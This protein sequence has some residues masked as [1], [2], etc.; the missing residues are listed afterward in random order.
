MALG[1]Y[2]RRPGA[3]SAA[4][5]G[6]FAGLAYATKETFVIVAGGALLALAI[7][8][9]W[10]AKT[11]AAPATSVPRVKR[12]AQLLLLVAIALLVSFVFFSSF[13]RYPSGLVESFLAFGTYIG[14]GVGP[15]THAQ[16]WSYYLG[17]LS[18]SAS[19]GLVWTEGLVLVL[20]I[21]GLVSAAREAAGFWPRYIALYAVITTV[22]FS[23][24][25]YKT[26]WN[27]LPFYSALILVAGYGAAALAE[28]ARSRFA[29]SVL[30][31][32]LVA[33]A[34]H[35]AAQSWSASVRYGADPRNPYAYVH[36]SSD[37]M[38]LVQR[39][40]DLS[41]VDPSRSGMLI[42]LLAGPYEQWPLPWY[43]RRMTRVGYWARASETDLPGGAP[44][45]IASQENAPALD[46]VLGERYVAEMYGLR[47]GVFLTLYVERTLW[48][49][50]L[51]SRTAVVAP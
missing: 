19:G 36:T 7:A 38:R 45:L 4:A 32:V 20:A 49:R 1:R 10:T 39:V 46:A 5:A 30:A 44:V 51:A 42:K 24:V 29:R 18:Y 14:R 50:F 27:L 8:R 17:L 9:M 40:N 34:C 31:V 35:L 25:R 23:A 28:A 16:P 22:A 48:D 13:F 33:G 2:A 47:P 21:A 15:G 37:F 6:A 3:V 12:R 26:P 11:E 43:L 41:Q